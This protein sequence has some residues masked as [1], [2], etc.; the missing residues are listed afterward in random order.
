VRIRPGTA[1]DIAEV[2]RAYAEAWRT[3][4]QGITPP[5]FVNGMTAGGAAQI[6]RESLQPNEFSYF[7]YVAEAPGGRLVGFADGGKERSHPERGIGELYAIYLL[8]EFQ[9]QGVGR[10]LFDAA[11]E[12]LL[13]SGMNS[14]VVWVLE[15][16]PYRK[17]YESLQG[18]L[19][20]GRKTLVVAGTQLTLVSYKWDD[21]SSI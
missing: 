8:K 17:F 20:P 10:K 12:T 18:K 3:T 2:S 11:V 7:F 13:K 21:L 4:Y 14:M 15:P 1:A 5:A 9:Q 19:E 16:S 6:F